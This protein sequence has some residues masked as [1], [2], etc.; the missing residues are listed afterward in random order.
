ML[1]PAGEFPLIDPD[2]F[3]K[4][5]DTLLKKSTDHSSDDED[6][7]KKFIRTAIISGNY[8]RKGDGEGKKK[9]RPDDDLIKEYL[10]S[11]SVNIIGGC[12]GTTPEYIRLIADEASKF[13]PRNLN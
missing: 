1:P 13:K 8:L 6:G 12:C 2:D 9:E 7:I 4:I 5:F 3:P 11:N 10:K